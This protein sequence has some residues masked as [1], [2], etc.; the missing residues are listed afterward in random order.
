MSLK[1]KPH[2]STTVI[3]KCGMQIFEQIM[4]EMHYEIHMK[5]LNEE[6]GDKILESI[7]CNCCDIWKECHHEKGEKCFST[8]RE[9]LK[10]KKVRKI[11]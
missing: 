10:P 7:E 11:I 2:W 3:E 8:W 6:T 4:V 1:E 5:D 9:T